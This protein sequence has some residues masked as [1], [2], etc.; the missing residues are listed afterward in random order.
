MDLRRGL[1]IGKAAVP[2]S[3]EIII[4]GLEDRVGVFFPRLV[5]VAQDGIEVEIPPDISEG[6]LL[7]LLRGLK[8][9]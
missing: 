1:P 2:E 4:D 5:S 9:C 7:T 6:L 8:E 3:A